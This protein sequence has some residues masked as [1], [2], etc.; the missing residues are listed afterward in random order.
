MFS[1]ENCGGVTLSFQELICVIMDNI[2]S[3]YYAKL[4]VSHQG[5]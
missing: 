4:C 1:N 5:Q 3:V 2:P